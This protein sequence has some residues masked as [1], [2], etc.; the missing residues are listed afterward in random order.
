[1]KKLPIGSSCLISQE[2]FSLCCSPLADAE[3]QTMA[4]PDRVAVCAIRDDRVQ[5]V[6]ETGHWNPDLMARLGLTQ[7]L[8]ALAKKV[9]PRRKLKPSPIV[10]ITGPAQLDYPGYK[11]NFWPNYRPPMTTP[12]PVSIAPYTTTNSPNKY[13]PM[14]FRLPPG[15]KVGLVPFGSTTTT[16]TTTTTDAPVV[17]PELNRIARPPV[18]AVD[19]DDAASGEHSWTENLIPTFLRYLTASSLSQSTAKD[20]RQ[21]RH[22]LSGHL[23]AEEITYM[24]RIL[25]KL[26]LL[27]NDQLPSGNATDGVRQGS[28]TV[29][30]SNAD[31]DTHGQ[32]NSVTIGQ[33]DSST[34]PSSFVTVDDT[35]VSK[36]SDTVPIPTLPSTISDE[37]V[38]TW[39]AVNDNEPTWTTPVTSQAAAVDE[40]TATTT[41]HLRTMPVAT[42]ND[43]RSR[44]LTTSPAETDPFHLPSLS[45]SF[46]L[47]HFYRCS[48]TGPNLQ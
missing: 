22:I 30:T 4:Q 27:F 42:V 39:A 34:T 9:K 10:N 17:R 1:M 35:T 8:Q 44:L 41:P 14:Q 29:N 18:Q 23:E 33:E 48:V 2:C 45:L 26:S 6:Q 20:G 24:Q 11:P 47:F 16:T 15:S 38:T 21:E 40:G 43:T 3:L 28:T 36:P 32:D 37:S 12:G 5:C 7:R 25:H 46:S 31:T 13:I 19:E